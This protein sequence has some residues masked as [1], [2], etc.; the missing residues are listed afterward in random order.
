MT[1]RTRTARP[2]AIARVVGRTLGVEAVRKYVPGE[3]VWSRAHIR[4]DGTYPHRDIGDVLVVEDDL[5][6]VREAW[7]FLGETFYTVEFFERAVVVIMRGRE[8]VRSMLTA[9]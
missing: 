8:M 1:D 9:A 3:L 4:N 7:S 2:A 6:C 5:G